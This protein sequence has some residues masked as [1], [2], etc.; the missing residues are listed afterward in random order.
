[1]DVRAR[2]ENSQTIHEN[3]FFSIKLILGEQFLKL[4]KIDSCFSFLLLTVDCLFV[5]A[6]VDCFVIDFEKF[7]DLKMKKKNNFRPKKNHFD[8]FFRN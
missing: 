2:Y 3:Q 1:M 7:F 6:T 5:I 8:I 4:E